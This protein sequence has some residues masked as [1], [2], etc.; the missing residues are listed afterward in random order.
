[1]QCAILSLEIGVAICCTKKNIEKE[2]I[3]GSRLQNFIGNMIAAE[4][5]GEL[6]KLSAGVQRHAFDWNNKTLQDEMSKIIEQ[7]KKDHPEVPWGTE[8]GLFKKHF[9][10][11]DEA[12]DAIDNMA[13]EGRINE[14]EFLALF[15]EIHTSSNKAAVA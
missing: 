8:K 11:K 3:M 10:E 9:P 6:R 1:L 13:N 14:L 15:K 7:F 2:A 4:Q 12:L 5:L